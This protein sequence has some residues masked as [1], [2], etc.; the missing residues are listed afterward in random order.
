MSLTSGQVEQLQQRFKHFSLAETACLFNEDQ[1]DTGRIEVKGQATFPAVVMQNDVAWFLDKA[2]RP[3]VDGSNDAPMKTKAAGGLRRLMYDTLGGDEL[4]VVEGEGHMVACVS[5]GMHGVV[6]AGGV[7]GILSPRPAAVQDRQQVFAGKSVRLLFDPD[8]AGQ[9]AVTKAA[10]K[11]LKAGALRVAIVRPENWAA[12][13]DVEDWLATFDTPQLAYGSLLQLLGAAS[14]D[15]AEEIKAGTDDIER[16]Q[17]TRVTV[18]GDE[19]PT[20]VVMVYDEATREASLAVF[21]CGGEDEPPLSEHDRAVLAKYGDTAAPAGPAGPDIVRGWQVLDSWRHNGTTYQPDV[22]GDVL[23]YVR[24]RTLVLPAPPHLGP[25]TSVELWQDVGAFM[26]RWVAVHQ[27]YYAVMAAYVFMGYRLED[28]EFPY[29]P[30]LRFYGR[31]GTGKGRALDV[32]K[33]ICWR[34]LGSQPTADNIHRMV[35]YF[36]DITLLF[37]EFHLD[38]GTSRETMERMIDTLCQGNK[39]GEGKIRMVPQ[40]NG[41]MIVRIFSLFGPKVFAGYGSDEVE[42]MVRRTISVH[43]GDVDVPESMDIFCLPPEFYA[44]AQVLRGRLLAW[45][46]RKLTAGLPDPRGERARR[47]HKAVGS[48]VG[49]VFWPLVEMVPAKLPDELESII[50]CAQQRVVDTQRVRE[51]SDESY[52]LQAMASLID[53]NRSHQEKPGEHFV[54]TQDVWDKVQ[55]RSYPA[56]N[57][58]ARKLSGMGVKHTRRRIQLEGSRY[59]SRIGGMLVKDDD[60]AL[61]KLMQQHGIKWPRDGESTT[62]QKEPAL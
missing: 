3:V 9:A 40:R 22:E 37:D 53:E 38:R 55:D 43:M 13:H 41:D 27:G 49:Q 52:L 15:G 30:Y 59:V 18:S 4:L 10:A 44:E 23:K 16:V 50:A 54:T 2:S 28:A 46:G 31:P 58:V 25:D 62:D 24:S 42:A 11:I 14:W 8:P 29:V 26:A 5:V 47:L 19:H 36:G 21:G 57:W 51:V 35:E 32:M 17:S 34:G 45:R 33:S 60:A 7:N 1:P 6:C 48:E 39:R 12:G 61:A 20:L 56:A